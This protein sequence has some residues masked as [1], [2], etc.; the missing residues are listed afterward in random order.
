M[1]HLADLFVGLDL[2]WQLLRFVYTKQELGNCKSCVSFVKLQFGSAPGILTAAQAPLLYR[3][4]FLPSM[5]GSSSS[6]AGHLHV[7][8]LDY[9][10]LNWAGSH[11]RNNATNGCIRVDQSPVFQWQQPMPH[12]PPLS[13]K[14]PPQLIKPCLLGLGYVK[15]LRYWIKLLDH[16]K[17]TSVTPPHSPIFHPASASCSRP[18]NTSTL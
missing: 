6:Q 9:S 18:C 11:C 3:S 2:S 12:M 8:T 14:L 10:L 15:L 16:V 13:N 17:K 7:M 1:E 5:S 4:V